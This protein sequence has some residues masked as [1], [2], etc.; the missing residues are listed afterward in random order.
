[1]LGSHSLRTALVPHVNTLLSSLTLSPAVS[2][3]PA[4]RPQWN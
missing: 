1:V 3:V 4:A 2:D